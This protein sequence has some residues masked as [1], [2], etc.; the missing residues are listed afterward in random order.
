MAGLIRRTESGRIV[1]PYEA[2]K[3]EFVLRA[4]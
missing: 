3:V 1:F 4:A 2:I